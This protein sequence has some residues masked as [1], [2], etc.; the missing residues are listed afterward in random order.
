MYGRHPLHHDT[1][2][3]HEHR[4]PSEYRSVADELHVKRR[5]YV[6]RHDCRYVPERQFVVHPEVEVYGD[7]AYQ[8][9]HAAAVTSASEEVGHVEKARHDEPCREYA[10]EAS[11]VES[12]QAGIACPCEPQSDTAQKQEYIHSH[13]AAAVE[14]EERIVAS[15]P[16]VEQYDEEHRQPHELASEAA[17]V[18]QTQNSCV[19]SACLFLTV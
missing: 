2:H 13:V 15:H 4:Q 18:C 3:H 11:G 1:P 8:V 7:V 14:S 19:R 9:A 10:G 6:E 5:G 16:Y 17:Y 12:A